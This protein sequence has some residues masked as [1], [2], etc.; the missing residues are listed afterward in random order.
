M[1]LQRFIIRDKD[2]ESVKARSAWRAFATEMPQ[3][4]ARV[5]IAARRR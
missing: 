4:R 3:A 1:N 2:E 5:P